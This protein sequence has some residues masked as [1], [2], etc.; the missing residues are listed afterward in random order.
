RTLIRGGLCSVRTPAVFVGVGTDVVEDV[1]AWATCGVR[2]PAPSAATPPSRDRRVI[3]VMATCL[4]WAAGAARERRAPA[5]R[6]AS[7]QAGRLMPDPRS[8]AP[9][10]QS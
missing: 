4:L 9:S 10:W 6:T 7:D 5:C 3:A 1:P 8:F 2:T